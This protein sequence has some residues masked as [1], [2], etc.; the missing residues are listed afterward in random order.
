MPEFLV[1]ND[2]ESAVIMRKSKND[3]STYFLFYKNPD[4]L[5]REYIMQNLNKNLCLKDRIKYATHLNPFGRHFHGITILAGRVWEPLYC[6]DENAEKYKQLENVI[7]SSLP[8]EKYSGGRNMCSF[9]RINQPHEVVNDIISKYK[10]LEA[11]YTQT[12]IEQ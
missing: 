6:V 9:V 12:E 3:N 5:S 2:K 11:E 1:Y 7:L 4:G 8:D 10:N